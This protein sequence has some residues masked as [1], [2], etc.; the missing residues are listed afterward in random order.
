MRRL[1]HVLLGCMAACTAFAVALA[2]PSASP[3]DDA[4]ATTAA[5]RVIET[6][7]AIEARLRT[8]RYQARTRVDLE[9]GDFRWDCSGMVGWI[10]RRTAPRAFDGLGRRRPVAADFYRVASRAPVDTSRRGWR[11]VGH[12][13]DARPGDVAAWRTPR[14]FGATGHVVILLESP[15]PSVLHPRRWIARI[16]DS[17]RIPHWADSRRSAAGGFG[18]GVMSFEADAEGRV[19]AWGWLGPGGPHFRGDVAIGRVVR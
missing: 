3:A 7:D 14:R 2:Q 16:A 9:A 15:R 11:R 19:V 4:P 1:V 8:T 10:V 5:A 12:V 6:V 17:T 18:T 13:R